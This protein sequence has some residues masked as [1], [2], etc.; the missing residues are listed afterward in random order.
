MIVLLALGLASAS[1]ASDLLLGGQEPGAWAARATGGYPWSRAHIACGLSGGW[2]VLA[3]YQ[4]ALLRRHQA[5]IGVERRWV[6]RRWRV[7]GA[8]VG[9]YLYQ[10]A[11][12]ARSG[13]TA[14][15]IIR[16]GRTGRVMP[17]LALGTQG[18]LSPQ[19]IRLVTAEGDERS[20]DLLGELTLTGTLGGAVQLSERVGLDVGLDLDW[21]DVPAI[22][23]PG[24]HVGLTV[25]GGR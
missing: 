7:S 13:P 20:I 12:L 3:G 8:V 22:S 5:T 6:D 14:E 11:P 18:T 15:A 16:A 23:I 19:R 17:Y 25:G 21:V 10:V 1:P 4:T 9:G 24:L 2:T